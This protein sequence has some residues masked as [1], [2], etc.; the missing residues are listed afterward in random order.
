MNFPKLSR[1]LSDSSKAISSGVACLC[2][3]R[4]FFLES[5]ESLYHSKNMGTQS[6][7]KQGN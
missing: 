6:W 5:F 4:L 1:A 3:V 7:I 2:K